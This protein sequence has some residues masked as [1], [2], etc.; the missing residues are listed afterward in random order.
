MTSTLTLADSHVHLDDASFNSDRDTVIERARKAGVALQIIPGVDAASWPH[1][2]ALCTPGSGLFPAYGLHPMFLQRHRPEDLAALSDW[3]KAHR[4]VAVGEIGLDFYADHYDAEGQRGYFKQQ[5]A[6][7]RE[8]DLPV[9]LHARAALD[10]I[11]A[12]L[13][14]VGS[15]RGVVHSFAGSQQQAEQLWKLGFQIGIGGPVTYERAQRL[16]QIVSKM[17]IEYLLLESD[18]PDQPLSTH[19]GERNEPAYVAE[20]LH[21]IAT[22][23]G[24]APAAIAAATTANAKRLFAIA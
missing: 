2:Q 11:T 23:R 10:E 17:P 24:E 6:L 1:I 12:S 22:L 5:L 8:F 20:V 9:I 19:R 16:R 21:C 18:A 3:L 15:L 14:R 4:P 7:A 13:R